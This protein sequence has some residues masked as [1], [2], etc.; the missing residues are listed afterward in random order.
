[1]ETIAILKEIGF[2]ERDATLIWDFGNGD[3]SAV[4][5]VHVRSGHAI[6][7]NG[8]VATHRTI[9]LIDTAMPL[10]VESFEHGLAWLAYACRKCAP[11]R[12]A[13]WLDQGR[14]LQDLL[15]WVKRR[16][17]YV[18]CPKCAVS[19]DWFRLAARDLRHAAEA[20]SPDDRASFEFDGSTLRINFGANALAVP[21]Q[22]IAWSEPACVDLA[23]LTRMPKRFRRDPVPLQVWESALGI[24][25]T[26][27]PLSCTP[28]TKGG[29][30][31]P[32]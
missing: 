20:A 16:S 18:A 9:A 26:N 27:F 1:M 29:S 7:L 19:R 12:P 31:E 14:K 3:L 13:A 23:Q 2:T 30:R 17:E 22:G 21:A 25:A 11:A 28:E 5:A 24:D 8:S 4:E 6:Y 10:S 32:A 15:P